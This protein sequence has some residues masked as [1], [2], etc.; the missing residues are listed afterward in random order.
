MS[1]NHWAQNPFS[2]TY[3]ANFMPYY[4]ILVF[5]DFDFVLMDGKDNI[6]CSLDQKICI[7]KSADF[8]FNE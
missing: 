8:F 7:S 2:P 5:D 3:R 1:P 4:K 6:R